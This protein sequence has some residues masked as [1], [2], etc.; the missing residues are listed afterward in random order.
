MNSKRKSSCLD[1]QKSTGILQP[2]S[3][4]TTLT[5]LDELILT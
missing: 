4:E 5:R 2:Y 3:V 1:Y